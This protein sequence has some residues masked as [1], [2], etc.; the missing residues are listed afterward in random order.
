[1]TDASMTLSI[2][3]RTCGAGYPPLMIAEEGQANEG[4]HD[5]ALKMIDIAAG[6]GADGIEFQL[7]VADDLYVKEE[8]GHAIYSQRE[9]SP[10][11]IKALVDR[12]HLHGLIFQAASLSSSLVSVCADAGADSFCVNAMDIDNPAM[13]SAVAKTGKPFWIATLMSTLADVDWAVDF[14]KKLG[15]TTFGLLHGQHVMSSGPGTDMP[16][17]VMQLDCID[18]FKERYGIPVGYVDHTSS[19]ETPALVA[20][21][22]ADIVFKHLAPQKDWKGPDW[23]VAL[24]PEQ[25]SAA[26]KLLDKAA[27][28]RGATKEVGKLEA[29]DQPIHRRSLRAAR[30]LAAGEIVEEKDLIGLRPGGGLSPRY[31]DCIVGRSLIR[32]LKKHESISLEDIQEES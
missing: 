29:A 8:E 12:A 7:S 26:R 30:D 19:V 1:M 11:Q 21:N 9:F 5:F 23:A 17:D 2:G 32:D 14:V 31:T 20:M 13:L 27:A 22:N 24:P 10:E 25:F 15:S 16:P 18:M 4:D 3:S 6:A 28:M